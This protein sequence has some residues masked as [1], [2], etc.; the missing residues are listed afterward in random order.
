MLWLVF[1]SERFI[2]TF[3]SGKMSLANERSIKR[4]TIYIENNCVPTN[5]GKFG[6]PAPRFALSFGHVAGHHWNGK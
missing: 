4:A 3:Q 6:F 2:P 1:T 5:A